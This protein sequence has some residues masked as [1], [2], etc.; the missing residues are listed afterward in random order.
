MEQIG[1]E[2]KKTVVFAF[3]SWSEMMRVTVWRVVAL[4]IASHKDHVSCMPPT[5]F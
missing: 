1:E 4:R 3:S 2:D 5:P